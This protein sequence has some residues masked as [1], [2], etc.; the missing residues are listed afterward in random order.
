MKEKLSEPVILIKIDTTGFS[1]VKDK[2]IQV[3]AAKIDTEGKVISKTWTINPGVKIPKEATDIHGITDSD[4]VDAPLFKDVA[5]E[6]LKALNNK[7]IVGW[8]ID[9]FDLGFL[10][11]EFYDCGVLNFRPSNTLDLFEV[12]KKKYDLKFE[13]IYNLQT[14]KKALGRIEV[15]NPLKQI[16]ELL[17]STIS[18]FY[19]GHEVRDIVLSYKEKEAPY[20]Y[21]VTGSLV[22]DKFGCV[23][24]N[25]GKHKGQKVKDNKSYALW[26][27]NNAA[28]FHISTIIIIKNELGL[29]N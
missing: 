8:Y 29:H 3:H 26:M 4:V 20:H 24:F 23:L 28:S 1:A 15:K 19:S 13:N 9:S 11:R 10:N 21:D 17:N 12:F 6:L 22:K 25:F 2:I 27:I 16:Y 18:S 7:V 5:G 14:G